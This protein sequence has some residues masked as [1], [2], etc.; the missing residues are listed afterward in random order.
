MA[1]VVPVKDLKFLSE[2]PPRRVTAPSPFHKHFIALLDHKDRWALL[3][4]GVKASQGPHLRRAYPDYEIIFRSEEP[5]AKMTEEKWSLYVC[6]RG[7]EYYLQTQANKRGSYKKEDEDAT[8][9][10]A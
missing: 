2:P 6:Y 9:E 3:A 10:S 1:T 4:T 8:D 5:G 7:T